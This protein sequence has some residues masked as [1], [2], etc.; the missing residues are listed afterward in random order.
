MSADTPPAFPAQTRSASENTLARDAAQ[1]RAA[2][3]AR[4]LH[5]D[6]LEN[7]RIHSVHVYAEGSVYTDETIVVSYS[8]YYADLPVWYGAVVV[9][10]T[11]SGEIRMARLEPVERIAVRS[12]EPT[13]TATEAER[14]VLASTDW[15]EAVR[16]VS[17]VD[18]RPLRPEDY[19]RGTLAVGGA[20]TLIIYAPYELRYT[21]DATQMYAEPTLAWQVGYGDDLIVHEV[22]V[23]DAHTGAVLH[24]ESL[25]RS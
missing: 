25:V 6:P 1:A 21:P 5:L 14:I 23:V 7:L 22:A 15:A 10:M 18:G 4:V 19:P 11:R 17:R 16:R 20:A 3:V 2:Q 12:I 13:V 24:R 9:K 8:R